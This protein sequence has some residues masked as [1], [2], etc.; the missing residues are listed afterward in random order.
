VDEI[1]SQEDNM[2]LRDKDEMVGANLIDSE[3]AKV[4]LILVVDVNG[5]DK[6]NNNKI[7]IQQSL[8]CH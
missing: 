7:Q 6:N 1:T 5:G 3:E 4:G 8:E 2:Q